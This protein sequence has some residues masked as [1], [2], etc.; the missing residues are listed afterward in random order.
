[1]SGDHGA[2]GAFDQRAS[3]W[4]AQLW[5]TTHRAAVFAAAAGAGALVAF[6]LLAARRSRHADV[7][8]ACAHLNP[9]PGPEERK[10]LR[11]LLERGLR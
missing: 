6:G 2:H 7:E 3:D 8:D 5:T 11:V 4:S 9:G 10:E 1:V